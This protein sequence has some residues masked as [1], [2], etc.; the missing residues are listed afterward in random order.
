MP[1]AVSVIAFINNDISAKLLEADLRAR[2]IPFSEVALI[3]GR[4]LERGWFSECRVVLRYG[5]K[6]A[7]NLLGQRR[8]ISFYRRA[9]RLVR[10]IS[11]SGWLKHIYIV[12]NDNL[13]CSHLISVASQS[14]NIDCTV[15]AE[16]LMNYQAITA[17]N[18]A[19]WRWRV[20]P[21]LA[22]LLLLRYHQP[23]GHLSGAYDNAVT[24]VVAFSEQGLKAPP[25]KAVIHRFAQATT[26]AGDP[27][28][29]LIA[30]TS[31]WQWM[32]DE[33]YRPFAEGFAEWI[34]K[35]GFQKIYAK[36]HPR[37][38]TGYLENLLPDHQIL[39]SSL[40]LE[41]LA[42]EMEMGVVIGTCCTALATLKLM[43]PALRCI[44]YGGD[45]Y[46]DHAYAGDKSVLDLFKSLDI[47][48]ISH[49]LNGNA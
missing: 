25:E 14:P 13:I 6:A 33:E 47:E 35:Q 4:E 41:D 8:F 31:L 48:L 5:G 39:L 43:R 17:K 7:L 22:M 16:G 40:P 1:S 30:H 9:S 10:E 44:D 36:P 23:E 34:K 19:S 42:E 29:A 28:I 18:R 27:H 45:Y 3:I 32:S 15:I 2:S 11:G 12:N 26:G 20:K 38:P 46:T 49:N 37:Y 21:L 24:R